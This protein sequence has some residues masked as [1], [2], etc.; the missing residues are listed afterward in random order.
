MDVGEELAAVVAR[1]ACVITTLFVRVA[2]LDAVFLAAVV[3]ACVCGLHS[4]F[5]RGIFE[6]WYASLWIGWNGKTN[7][8]Q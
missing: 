8:P 6:A 1:I 3:A 4:D 2:G 5:E 7:A